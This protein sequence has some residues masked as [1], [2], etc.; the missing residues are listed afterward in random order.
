MVLEVSMAKIMAQRK[1]DISVAILVE[2]R[3]TSG[4][5]VRIASPNN[6]SQA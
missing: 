5:G 1:A 3:L 2:M 6:N 4:D